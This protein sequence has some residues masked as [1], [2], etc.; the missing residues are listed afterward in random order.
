LN[1][2]R[3]TGITIGE[4]VLQTKY[5]CFD[6]NTGGICFGDRY[7]IGDIYKIEDKPNEVVCCEQ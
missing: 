2:K 1:A 3:S 6:G 7:I 5:N 4:T